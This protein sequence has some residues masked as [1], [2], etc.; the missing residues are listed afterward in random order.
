MKKLTVIKLEKRSAPRY[1]PFWIAGNVKRTEDEGSK[2]TERKKEASH[3]EAERHQVGEA[4]GPPLHP[5]L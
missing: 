4:D 2:K 3:E 5:V 1:I